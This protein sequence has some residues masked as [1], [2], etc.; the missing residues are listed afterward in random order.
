MIRFIAFLFF[1]LPVISHAASV[2]DL[3]IQ[4][5]FGEAFAALE[6]TYGDSPQT[7][8]YLL[9]SGLSSENGE[10]SILDL[11]DFL[12]RG[13]GSPY[14]IDWARM[15]LGKY[16]ISQGLLGTARKMFESVPEMS[17]FAAEAAFL[18]GRCCLFSADFES[19]EKI[20]ADASKRFSP[21]KNK[22]Q[23]DFQTEY[24]YW[25][26]FG[27]AE[28]KS[29]LG[30]N[31][32]AE[33]LYKQFLEPQFESEIEPLALLGLARNARQA[34]KFDQANQYMNMYKEQYGQVPIGEAHTSTPSST[35]T[36]QPTTIPGNSDE[37]A[38]KIMGNKYY[39]QIGAYSKKTNADNEAAAYKKNGYKVLVESYDKQGQ[40]FYRVLLGSY[41]SK[42]QADYIKSKLEKAA[43][44]K[45]SL[46]VR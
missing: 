36:K 14:M 23:T 7:S 29:A 22:N 15:H 45:Y 13:E 1:A 30:Q 17:P 27:L 10:S 35:T 34:K 38:D 11:K 18:A 46:L 28:S 44:E 33:K 3:I 21:D 9:V 8:G 39:I 24:Y 41:S 42:T 16:Y 12:N 32:A 43:G 37:R 4:G 5:K 19:A 25:S 26:V 6:S 31:A 20:F 40:T 2:D